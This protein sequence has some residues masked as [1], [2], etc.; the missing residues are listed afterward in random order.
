M[1]TLLR[2]SALRLLLMV[3]TLLQGLAPL[4][5]AHAEG[6]LPGT[7]HYT[8]MIAEAEGVALHG[9]AAVHLQPDSD[10]VVAVADQLG[11]AEVLDVA[12]VT[13]RPACVPQAHE[14]ETSC[15]WTRQRDAPFDP[16]LHFVRPHSHAPPLR[17]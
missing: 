6:H 2:L 7:P 12:D 3:L 13:P 10:F 15:A 5:H 16:F 17:A 9:V 4:L 11:R 8:H 14:A 1:P